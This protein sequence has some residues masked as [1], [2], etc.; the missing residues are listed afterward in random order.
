MLL[1][2]RPTPVPSLSSQRAQSIFSFDATTPHCILYLG[3]L[4]QYSDRSEV[5]IALKK[6][7]ALIESNQRFPNPRTARQ[8]T[9]STHRPGLGE[10]VNYGGER[11]KLGWETYSRRRRFL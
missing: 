2:K 3:E 5:P 4:E 9:Q 7:K 6:I 8:L 10:D 1:G 11:H